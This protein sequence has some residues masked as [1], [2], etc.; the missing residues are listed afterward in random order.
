[1]CHVCVEQGRIHAVHLFFSVD[2]LYARRKGKWH[3][4]ECQEHDPHEVENF[5]RIS[6][7]FSLFPFL[8]SPLFSI[9]RENI[10]IVCRGPNSSQEKWTHASGSVLPRPGT[11]KPRGSAKKTLDGK[12]RGDASSC[13]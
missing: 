8:G 6:S 7:P 4:L 5:P 3:W 2:V 1:M 13:W 10:Y 11:G 9:N 12:S